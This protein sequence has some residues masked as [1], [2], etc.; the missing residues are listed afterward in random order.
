MKSKKIVKKIIFALAILLGIGL[1]IGILYV[2]QLSRKGL[3]DYNA[4]V[5]LEGMF[6]QVTVYRDAYA[7]PHIYAE[8]QEDLSRATGLTLEQLQTA[9]LSDTTKLPEEL[10]RAVQ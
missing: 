9:Q 8:N 10:Q 6:G 3:P 7:V 5:S 1:I 2:R 4:E